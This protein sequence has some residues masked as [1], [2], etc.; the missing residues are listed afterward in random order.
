MKYC[1][2]YRESSTYSF[3]TVV[4]YLATTK[5]SDHDQ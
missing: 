1:R 2:F 5:N 4:G 3:F